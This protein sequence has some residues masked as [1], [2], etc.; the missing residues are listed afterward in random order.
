MEKKKSGLAIAGGIFLLLNFI[1]FILMNGAWFFSFGNI[2]SIST[3]SFIGILF[4]AIALFTGHKDKLLGVA[5]SVMAFNTFIN[6][7]YILVW[8]LPRFLELEDFY[9]SVLTSI[10]ESLLFALL[11]FG[12]FSTD[13]AKV[14]K[15]IPV[16]I[17]LPVLL[18]VSS[19]IFIFDFLY[20]FHISALIIN[21]T[22]NLGL[23][24]A[25]L[26]IAGA[27]KK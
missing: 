19:V 25:G 21:L 18:S 2:I 16:Y 22:R 23:I 14:K 20:S 26:Y 7:L 3:V 11:I 4:V 12:T 9:I 17:L 8:N 1:L 27:G 13:T 6:T 5:L 10:V 24:F 15:L